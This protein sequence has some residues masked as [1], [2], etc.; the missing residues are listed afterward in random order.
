M[1]MLN[2]QFAASSGGISSLGVNGQSFLFNLITFAIVLLILRRW[3][4]PKLVKTL[5]DRRKTLEE[6]LVQARQTEEALA[7]AEV[8]AEELLTKARTQADAALA[9]ARKQAE[10]IIAK[11]ETEAGERAR[12]IIA[13]AEARLDIERQRLHQQL[14]RE[15]A[16]LVVTATEKVLRKKLDEKTDRE[17]IEKSLKELA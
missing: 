6:S 14:R 11:G 4:F 7:N 15:L 10:V 3:V 17:L 12:R 13:E 5:E 2:P 16:A 8:K 1:I 9:E